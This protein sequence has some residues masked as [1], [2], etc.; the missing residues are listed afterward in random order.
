MAAVG[1]A[2]NHLVSFLIHFPSS[3][4]RQ[5]HDLPEEVRRDIHPIDV[6]YAEPEKKASAADH[7]SGTLSDMELKIRG[8]L[9]QLS[10]VAPDAIGKRTTIFQLGLDSINAVQVAEMLRKRGLQI[11]ATDVLNCPTCEELAKR[12]DSSVNGVD[13]PMKDGE[14]Q[15]DQFQERVDPL[16]R[17][18]LP[19]G[20]TVD[21]ILPCT[22]VQVAMLTQ[23]VRSHGKHYMNYLRLDLDSGIPLQ[24]IVNALKVVSSA[25]EM[26]RVGFVSLDSPDYQD[27]SYVMVKHGTEARVPLSVIQSP[28]GFSAQKWKL[29][30]AQDVLT[31]LHSP[32]WRAALVQDGDRASMHVAIHHALYDASSLRRILDD[33]ARCIHRSSLPEATPVKRAVASIL[34]LVEQSDRGLCKEFWTSFA[35][36]A[37]VNKFPVMTP[38]RVERGEMLSSYHVSALTFDDLLYATRKANIS[39][40]AALQGAWTR[41]LSSYQGEDSVIFGTVMSGRV[42]EALQKAAFP[43]ITTVP[44]IAKNTSSNGELLQYMMEFNTGMYKH[45]FSRL[46]DIQRWLGHSGRPLFDTLLVYQRPPETNGASLPWKVIEDEGVVEYPLSLEIDP[47]KSGAVQLRMT[48]QSDVLPHEQASLMMAQFDAAL[49]H[50]VTEPKGSVD[51]LWSNEAQLAAVIPPP[52]AE[53]PSDVALL[54][55]FVEIQARLKPQNVALEFVEAFEG[56]TPV[57]RKWT[58]SELNDM[59]NRVAATLSS[60]VVPG[61]IV[62]VHFD[63]CP[64][65]YFSILGILKAGCSFLALDP[66]APRARKEFILGDSKAAAVLTGDSAQLDFSSPAPVIGMSEVPPSTTSFHIARP[67]ISPQSTCY[68]LYTSGT[69]GTP[70]GCEIT[71]ENAVQAI[72]AFRQLFTEHWDENSRCLQFAALHFDVSVLEQYWSWAVG[73]RL[74]SAPRDLVLDDLEGT[75]ARLGITHID[76]T[77]SLASLVRPEKAPSLQRGVFITGGEQLKQ[78]ILDAW[79]PKGVIWNFYGPT[80]ATIGVTV[81][82]QV[83]SNGRPANIGQQFP[84]VGTYVFRQGTDTPVPRGGVGELCVSGKLVGKGYLGREELTA[85]R[86]PVVQPWGERVYRTGDL[87]RLLHDGS[88]DFLGRADDQVKLRGQRLQLG[89]ID[90]AIRSG[91]SGVRDVVTLVA[92]HGKT[93]KDLLVSF[94]VPL[95]PGWK[96][97][98]SLEMLTSPEAL[99]IC[100]DAREACKAKVPG[101]MVP[102]Y[103]VP[104]PLVPLSRNNKTE[105]KELRAFFN[106]L[107]PEELSRLSAP[108]TQ[109]KAST[110]IGMKVIELVAEF[111][112]EETSAL[113][114]DTSVFELGLDSISVPRLSRML[115]QKGIP[116]SPDVI[117]KNPVLGDLIQ[118]LEEVPSRSVRSK[119]TEAR[120]LMR[121]CGHRYRRLACRELGISHEEIDYIAPCTPIQQGMLS[122]ALAA[123]GGGSAY[124]NSFQLSLRQDVSTERLM[125]AWKATIE[126]HAILRTR[127]VATPEGFVQVAL[128]RADIHWRSFAFGPNDWPREQK[129]LNAS[130]LDENSVHVVRPLEFIFKEDDKGPRLAIHVFHGLYDG[131]S[132]DTILRYVASLYRGETPTEGPAFENVLTQGPLWRYDFCRG[133][134][135]EHLR[136]WRPT[137]LPGSRLSRAEDGYTINGQEGSAVHASDVPIKHAMKIEGLERLR[138]TL[139]VTLQSVVLG[140]W[141]CT[142]QRRVLGS[143]TTGIIVSGRSLDVENIENCI[144]PLFNTLPFFAQTSQGETWSSLIRKCHDFAASVSAFQHVSL[145][146]IQK[147]CSNGKALFNNLFAFQVEGDKEREPLW[148]VEEEE[149]TADYPLAFEGTVREGWLTVSIVA[150]GKL[151]A[152]EEVEGLLETFCGC[153]EEV[154]ED[155]EACAGR[156]TITGAELNTEATNGRS[157]SCATGSVPVIDSGNLSGDADVF[158][159]ELCTICGLDTSEIFGDQTLANLGLDSIDTVRLSARVRSRGLGL[160]ASEIAR[161]ANIA[162]V[163]SLLGSRRP[164]SDSSDAAGYE[165]LKASLRRSVTEAGFGEDEIEDVLPPTPLQE[166]MVSQMLQTEC[167]QYFNHDMLE[168]RSGVDVDKLVEAWT[169]VW[170]TSPILRTVFVEVA[171]PE[172]DLSFCQVVLRPRQLEVGKKTL[173][174]ISQVGDVIQETRE[175]ANRAMGRDKLFRLHL[176]AIDG[177]IYVLFSIAHALYDGWSLALLHR[178]VEEAYRGRIGGHPS[179]ETF[180]RRIHSTGSRGSEFWSQYLLGAPPTMVSATGEKPL[181]RAEA[182][183]NINAAAVKSF[184]KTYGVSLQVLGQACW[185][186]VL[187]C[188]TGSLDLTFGVVLSG[189]DFEEAEEM[190]F[191]TMNTVAV[192]YLLHG[193]VGQFLRYMEDSMAGVREHQAYPLRKTLKG[194]ALFNTLFLFQKAPF[195]RNDDEPIMRSVDSDSAVEYPVCVELEAVGEELIWRTACQGSFGAKGAEM[196][197]YQLDRVLGYLIRSPEEEVLAFEHPRVSICGLAPVQLVEAAEGGKEEVDQVGG[198]WT[199]TETAIRDVVAEVSGTSAGDIRRSTTLYSV[200]LDSISAIKVAANLKRRGIQVSVRELLM[201]SIRDA[202]LSVES[203]GGFTT[204]AKAPEHDKERDARLVEKSCVAAGIDVSANEVEEVLPALPMQVYMLSMGQN[205]RGTV[206]RP[207]FHY[208]LSGQVS[209][210]VLQHAWACLVQEMTLLRTCFAVGEDWP[211]LQIVL[212]SGAVVQRRGRVLWDEEK[213]EEHDFVRMRARACEGGWLLWIKIHHALYDAVSM[214]SML[215]RFAELC[216]GASA[217]ETDTGAWR[218]FTK[219]HIL[220]DIVDAR[221]RFWMEY[222]SGVETEPGITAWPSIGRTCYFAKDALNTSNAKAWC[223]KRGVSFQALFFAAYASVLGGPHPGGSVIFGIYLANRSDAPVPDAYPTLNLVPLRV[224]L[225]GDLEAMARGVQADIHA[226]TEGGNAGVG[227]WEVERWTGV[228]VHSFVNFILPGEGRTGRGGV[229]LEAVEGE[230]AV[231]GERWPIPSWMEGNKVADCFPVSQAPDCAASLRSRANRL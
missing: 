141:V 185:A 201:G 195:E 36:D 166:T 144:G 27:M 155:P 176:L 15:V 190:R 45:Q 128:R 17:A 60:R 110:E 23:F 143:I 74:M 73:V 9:A 48:F 7:E 204:T 138:R 83:P 165:R 43:C 70:K 156:A 50:L 92:K 205:S 116:A 106:R 108:A 174:S 162:E 11:T 16:V 123:P 21:A 40:Q 224:E 82:R 194:K 24:S 79:G 184:G 101:Y 93:G 88:F 35:E 91:V 3:A 175:E 6:T 132:F 168:V 76:L 1:D 46:T 53:L 216:E 225:S 207:T 163:M 169:A 113:N 227:L 137:E 127:F 148:T 126:R 102:T 183:S 129:R 49:R 223:A 188:M 58:Y 192:R 97:A 13:T 85:E 213:E 41:V 51:S 119:V 31:S 140:L 84:N 5:L 37:V 25:H 18:G 81:R 221:R 206:F 167:Q 131:N 55:Q 56:D 151:M 117:L 96:D 114:E 8:V 228:Q 222:L 94:I 105:F 80:E 226:F 182:V 63:K 28:R 133:F 199:K 145:R 154:I 62:A 38:L 200:G 139:G 89:E 215:R 52:V 86:F 30:M 180:L 4:L 149:P 159:Q 59:G 90:H 39:I 125:D 198:E 12:L 72:L 19:P 214:S 67:E 135:V 210:E 2:V 150:S 181:H 202:A 22:P 152:R 69:T 57:S 157:Q 104:I 26:L 203:A 142:L 172:I 130:W 230:G 98:G 218:A 71:H 170:R 164:T 111:I 47:Q 95:S 34:G 211:F 209:K 171:N 124:F 186:A 75:I 118:A 120:Q 87:V 220:P 33:L 147:W 121:A 189:R 64:E 54:H 112:G 158:L 173:D 29:D 61:S 177:K 179:P 68:C 14:F 32:P 208:R 191:P 219:A 160:T 134:W 136:G 10:S 42:S 153:V 66:A 100:H 229:R 146:N 109:K 187:G 217:L 78:E 20:N 44:V 196:V 65:A 99:G 161:C 193:T 77:P 212:G 122:R 107:S 197:L 178:D 103:V 231:G 115:K